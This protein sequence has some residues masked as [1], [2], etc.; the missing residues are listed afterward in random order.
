M[1]R[2][3]SALQQVQQENA[4]LASTN[5]QLTR[6][7][8]HATDKI[9]SLRSKVMSGN[10]RIGQL[11]AEKVN[12]EHLQKQYE[13]LQRQLDESEHREQKQ[14]GEIKLL[15]DESDRL[16]KA[17]YQRRVTS[18]SS[19]EQVRELSRRLQVAE[20]RAE[21]KELECQSIANKYREEVSRE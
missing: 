12:P 15:R 13:H 1:L 2:M 8:E 3:S 20:D 14:G 18:D 7:L 11:K 10:E 4:A 21:M 17:D 9:T 16:R 19:D 5:V 6:N